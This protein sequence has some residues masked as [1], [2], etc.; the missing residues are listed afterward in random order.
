MNVYVISAHLT[1][2]PRCRA[3]PGTSSRGLCYF[4]MMMIPISVGGIYRWGLGQQLERITGWPHRQPC[5][6]MSAA[7][8]N[9]CVEWHLLKLSMSKGQINIDT[10]LL[11]QCKFSFFDWKVIPCNSKWYV[12]N[13]DKILKIYI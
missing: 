6:I 7:F 3:E 2:P 8:G 13:Y 4:L 10:C 12:H 1:L 9:S 11:L 5:H